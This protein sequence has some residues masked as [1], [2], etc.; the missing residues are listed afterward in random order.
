MFPV[1][2]LD[3]HAGSSGANGHF[4]QTGRGPKQHHGGFAKELVELSKSTT[5]RVAATA[6]ALLATSGVVT[7]TTAGAT[8]LTASPPAVTALAPAHADSGFAS[9]TL[10]ELKARVTA[11]IDRQAARV[12]ALAEKIQASDRLTA[13]QKARA[14]ARLEKARTALADLRTTVQS[15]TTKEGVVRALADARRDRVFWTRDGWGDRDGRCDG[16]RDGRNAARYGSRDGSRDGAR[17]ASWSG[18]RDGSS[19]WSGDR[20]RR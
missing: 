20:S 9:L 6:A 3:G 17:Y 4:G 10:D 16:D 14:A 19:H 15:Q 1:N 11:A 7:A 5:V 2:L 12:V 18:T 8:P 13:E